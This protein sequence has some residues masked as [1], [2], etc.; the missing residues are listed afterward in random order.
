MLLGE[1]P[2][3]D[4]EAEDTIAQRS[5][6]TIHFSMA[7]GCKPHPLGHVLPEEGQ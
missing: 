6:F 4:S 7:E 2:S 1:H 5:K 3:T